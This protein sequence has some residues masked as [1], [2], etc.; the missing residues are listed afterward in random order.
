ME[1]DDFNDIMLQTILLSSLAESKGEIPIKHIVPVMHPNDLISP[2]LT[3]STQLWK[4][5]KKRN[6]VIR[7][8]VI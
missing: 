3:L 2:I 4:I 7:N 5:Q 8:V 1:E 6:H